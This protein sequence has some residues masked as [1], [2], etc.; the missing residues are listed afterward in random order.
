M[1]PTYDLK[2][3]QLRLLQ[4]DNP[5]I[6]PIDTTIRFLVSSSDVIHSFSVPSLGI[7]VDAVP[8][9]LNQTSFTIFKPGMYYGAC[10][11]ICGIQHAFMPIV[12]KATDF[13]DFF[14]YSTNSFIS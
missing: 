5:L 4:T 13:T 7:K 2:M 9:R 3:G 12:I 10:Q 1:V 11:E 6:L 8:G 14:T